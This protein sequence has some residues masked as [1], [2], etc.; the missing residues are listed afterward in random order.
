MVAT[1]RIKAYARDVFTASTDAQ[2]FL[3]EALGGVETIKG[4]GIERPVR[5]KWEKKYVKALEYPVPRA[6]ASTSGS[7]SPASCSMPRSPSPSCG[8]APTW[9]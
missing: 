8:S 2:A 6:D 3:M 5:L 4:M 7:A 1:P 9:C